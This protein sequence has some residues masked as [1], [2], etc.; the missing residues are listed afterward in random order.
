MFCQYKTA[1]KTIQFSRIAGLKYGSSGRRRPSSPGSLKP[2]FPSLKPTQK[3]IETSIFK[4]SDLNRC[5]KLIGR[6]MW[7]F[8]YI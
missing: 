2:S 3:V 8:K 6:L 4:I 7:F 1:P 5:F